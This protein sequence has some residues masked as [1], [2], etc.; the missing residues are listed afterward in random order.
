MNLNIQLIAFLH[1]IYI[2]MRLSEF[3]LSDHTQ[4]EFTLAHRSAGDV[5]RI[6]LWEKP[7]CRYD[8]CMTHT[9]CRYQQTLK[10]LYFYARKLFQLSAHSRNRWTKWARAKLL[11]EC[12][13]SQTFRDLKILT[14][15]P[16]NVEL[17]RIRNVFGL[18]K[19]KFHIIT[20]T[21]NLFCI[22]LSFK[23]CLTQS[24]SA[25]T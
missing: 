13:E 16:Q 23:L 19:I 21:K 7:V 25:R 18:T 9:L 5:S 4:R 10:R 20:R 2:V 11:E 6:I 3:F 1:Y 22:F 14:I 24:L 17:K 8:V 12:W 15:S